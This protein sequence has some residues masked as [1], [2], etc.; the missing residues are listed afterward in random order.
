MVNNSRRSQSQI[1]RATPSNSSTNPFPHIHPPPQGRV[2]V[3]DPQDIYGAY[4]QPAYHPYQVP[5]PPQYQGQQGAI[6]PPRRDRNRPLG[7]PV[8]LEPPR[9]ET[10]KYPVKSVNVLS[11]S[12]NAAQPPPPPAGPV[13]N[14]NP[15][16]TYLSGF[17]VDYPRVD[18][19]RAVRRPRVVV[20]EGEKDEGSGVRKVLVGG[21]KVVVKPG[22]GLD[23]LDGDDVGEVF[24]PPAEAYII[25]R[26]H[27]VPKELW[28]DGV[29]G[30][31][32]D[33]EDWSYA[34]DILQSPTRGK[35]LGLQA[36]PRGFPS[37][38][39]P[40]IVQLRVYDSQ[41]HVIPIDSPVLSRRLV[42]TIMVVDLV[43]PDGKEQ[44]SSIK[45]KPNNDL[46]DSTSPD[47]SPPIYRR[48]LLGATVRASAVLSRGGGRH[49]ERGIYFVFSE[50]VVRNVGEFA[51]RMRVAD[52]A[53]PAHLGTSIGVT[54]TL[55]EGLTP[56]FEVLYVD[57]VSF[58][59]EAQG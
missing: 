1:T 32:T 35:A 24:P 5:Y 54:R 18:A 8:P 26:P 15:G 27:R 57:L 7:P 36:L 20:E 44:R 3:Y 28:D 46:H 4:P 2:P 10:P 50:L 6:H 55:V 29:I 53:G 13:S 17:Q 37:L 22:V 16:K 51:L 52:L 38:T 33:A 30:N 31:F 23:G 49:P 45:L 47:S 12:L 39:A 21:R 42:H 58:T 9:E 43:S 34:V 41:G 56:P 14:N 48:N 19:G 25:L 59:R 11:T 40:L